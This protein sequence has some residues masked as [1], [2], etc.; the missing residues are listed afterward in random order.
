MV[1]EKR[2]SGED[3]ECAGECKLIAVGRTTKIT[4][5]G[6]VRRCVR[7]WPVVT[8]VGVQVELRLGIGDDIGDDTANLEV[9]VRLVWIDHRH[10][11]CE[12][13]AQNPLA[14]DDVEIHVGAGDGDAVHN[15]VCHPKTLASRA[16]RPRYRS[17]FQ[18]AQRQ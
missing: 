8:V 13:R 14:F 7:Q 3:V 18:N 1:G 12:R 6:R 9:P 15:I 16:P 10:R 2:Q 17:A 11:H 5:Y 4:R